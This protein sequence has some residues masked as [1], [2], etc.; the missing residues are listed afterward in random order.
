MHMG[1]KRQIC[2]FFKQSLIKK[3]FLCIVISDIQGAKKTYLS[4]FQTVTK[5]S[6][7]SPPQQH[8]HSHLTKISDYSKFWIVSY[9]S[10][11]KFRVTQIFVMH[12]TKMFK[13]AYLY[14]LSKCSETVFYFLSLVFLQKSSQNYSTVLVLQKYRG[15]LTYIFLP[16]ITTQ[17]MFVISPSFIIAPKNA[18]V[19]IEWI[20]MLLRC[21]HS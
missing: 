8:C 15:A 11:E 18:W 13:C 6:T 12:D 3:K 20:I 7:A 19:A 2:P 14:S 1:L 10:F 9:T 21:V 5:I 17:T 16:C 4:S